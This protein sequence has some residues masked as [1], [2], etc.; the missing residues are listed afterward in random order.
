MN[1]PKL[2]MSSS[3]WIFAEIRI[4]FKNQTSFKILARAVCFMFVVCWQVLL[5]FLLW[6]CW[7]LPF[8]SGV[9]HSNPIWAFLI[10]RPN[11]FAFGY[12][13]LSHFIID[14]LWRHLLPS[15][16]SNLIRSISWMSIDLRSFLL[17]SH[18]GFLIFQ[19]RPTSDSS[20]SIWVIS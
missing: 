3:A 17:K 6:V 1:I 8:I 4:F 14:I 15:N 18:L 11:A 10:F 20:I 13:H 7:I 9:F 2:G 19:L 16:R 12:D 5:Q